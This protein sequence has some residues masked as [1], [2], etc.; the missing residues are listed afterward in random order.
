MLVGNPATGGV[1]R[2]PVRFQPGRAHTDREFAFLERRFAPRMVFMEIGG[3]DCGLALRAAGYV[4]RVYA[5]DVCGQFI[6]SVLVPCNLRLVRCDGVHIPVPDASIDLAWSGAFMDHLHP[7]DAHEH[8]QSVRRS[9]VA[10]GEYLCRTRAAP[11]GVR[12]RLLEAGFSA[13]RFYAGIARIPGAI[14]SLVPKNLL[15]ISAIK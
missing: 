7:D 5:V 1:L 13:V 8:L 15:C 14:L 12:R 6:E 10:G 9:L 11:R 4:D 2:L 3:A